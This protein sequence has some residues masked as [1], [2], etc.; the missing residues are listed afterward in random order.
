MT[1]DAAAFPHPADTG[2]R[3]LPPD[4]EYICSADVATLHGTLAADFLSWS[5]RIEEMLSVELNGAA[6]ETL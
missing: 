1:P 4:G 2:S 6:L 5:K 3:P